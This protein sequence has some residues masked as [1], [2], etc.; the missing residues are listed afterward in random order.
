MGGGA[1]HTRTRVWVLLVAVLH[2][3]LLAQ[4]AAGQQCG[5]SICYV[6]C[7]GGLVHKRLSLLMYHAAGAE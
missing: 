4:Q 6:S 7:K 3:S 1:T 5:L 2:C